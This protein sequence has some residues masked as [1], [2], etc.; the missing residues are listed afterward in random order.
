MHELSVTQN[1]LDIALAEAEKHNAKRIST[2]KLKVGQLTQVVPDCVQFYLEMLGK[3]T[4]AE[5]VKLEVETVPLV[6][7][8]KSC[9]TTATLDEYDFA[10]RKCSSP[11]D[12]ISGRELF[13]D[14]I[15]VE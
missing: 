2:I 3:G 8:C 11:T 9:G 12:V 4:I 14:S 13:I 10:C 7:Q 6:V 5:G 15:E 1:I